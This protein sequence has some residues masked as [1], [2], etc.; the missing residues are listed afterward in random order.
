VTYLIE[1]LNLLLLVAS[2]ILSTYYYIKS[3]QPARLEQEIGEVAYD[4]CERY[5]MYGSIPYLFL[6]ISYFIY[7][8]FPLPLPIPNLLPWN[9]SVSIL[10]AIIIA[11]PAFT[12][13]GLGVR[14]AGEETFRPKKEHKLYG[15]IYNKI[16]HPQS[17]GEVWTGIILGLILNSTFLLLYSFLWFPVFYYMVVVEE[18]DLILRYGESYVEYKNRVGMFIPKRTTKTT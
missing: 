5:R 18:R 10:V 9:Y 7:F 13:M 14:A 4:K 16:R 15:G 2:T 3:V 1:W 8:F 11:I 12:L 17:L 6:F